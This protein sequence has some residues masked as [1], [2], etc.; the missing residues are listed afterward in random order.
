[1][2]WLIGKQKWRQAVT[3]IVKV[4]EN[5]KEFGQAGYQAK[6]Y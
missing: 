1:M 4:F 3:E 6:E 2:N 5:P